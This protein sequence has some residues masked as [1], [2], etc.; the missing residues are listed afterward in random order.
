LDSPT[1]ATNYTMGKK[2]ISLIFRSTQIGCF[3]FVCL[4]RGEDMARSRIKG[5]T[6]ELDGE[7][8]GLDKAL[9]GVNKTTR[10]LQ[11]ELR[12]VEKLLKFSPDN[13]E[14]LEQKQKLLNDQVD[15][16]TKKLK[17][18]KDAQEQVEKQFKSG[19]IGEAQYRAFQREIAETESKL[20][21]FKRQAATVD[22]SI[23]SRQA[24]KKV[25]K[26]GDAFKRAGKRAADFARESKDAAAIGGGAI[27][28]G[29]AGLVGGNQDYNEILA[30]LKTNAEIKE[31]DYKLVQQAF[32][33]VVGI[34]GE[35]DSAGETISNLLASGIKDTQL[36]DYVNEIN[37]AYINFSDTLKTEGIA[38]GIQETLATG[39]AVGPFAE[40]LERSGINLEN[41]NSTLGAMIKIGEG[42]DYIL[43]TLSNQGLAQVTDK[44]KELNPEVTK[45]AEAN[46]EFQKALADLGVALTPLMIKVTEFITKLADWAAE[47][48]VLAQTITTIGA[49][50][51]GIV[52][53]FTF[54]SPII[55]MVIKLFP[56]I[57][58]R[59]IALLGPVGAVIAIIWAL[60]DI[61]LMLYRNWD[62]ISQKAGEIWTA[63]K[64]KIIT[65]VLEIATYVRNK[66]NEMKE[67]AVEKLQNMRDKVRGIMDKVKGIFESIDL[68]ES[69]KAIIQ[70]AIDGILSMKDKIWGKVEEV[71]GGVRDYWPFS[72]AKVGPLSDIHKMD[73]AGPISDSIKKAENPLMRSMSNLSGTVRNAMP[74][75]TGADV[76]SSTQTTPQANAVSFEGMFKGANF[77][78][79]NDNDIHKLAQEL[80]R[81]VN[82]NKGRAGLA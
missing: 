17:T 77:H 73:F 78:V 13:V 81:Y 37:G 8:K 57:G 1:K 22:D 40:L 7:T 30:R 43:K 21:T 52:A 10:D 14:L 41:F 36:L 27:A 42:S 48:P 51:T 65:K 76:S 69:G 56:Q 61:G 49:A 28:A 47:N 26:I 55:S 70:S 19:E 59:M 34:T 58:K 80:A 67:S 29:A 79:R 25:D 71:V 75:L 68:Y 74:Q 63:I 3:F 2:R 4:E 16:T 6:I 50:L 44:Y 31:A 45:N 32:D 53:V 24:V 11:S 82:R 66:F 18:L 38:D 12:D 15:N 46:A 39:E 72:P 23:D 9:S 20:Q 5:I 33:R 62:T 54:L 64:T 35:V 60:I